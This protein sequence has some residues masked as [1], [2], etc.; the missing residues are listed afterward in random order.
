VL[1]FLRKKVVRGALTDGN[2]WIFLLIKLNDNYEEAS[3]KQSN[4]I[5]LEVIANLVDGHWVVPKP[6]PDLIAAI[7]VHWVGSF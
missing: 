6:W 1:L 2:D 7:L 3:Y 4:V 5:K